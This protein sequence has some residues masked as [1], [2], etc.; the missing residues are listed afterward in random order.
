MKTPVLNSDRSRDDV[1]VSDRR[2]FLAAGIS[3]IAAPL[4]MER[5]RFAIGQAKR[6]RPPTQMELRDHAVPERNPTPAQ[7]RQRSP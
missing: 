4:L 3:L 7:V 1:G 6:H 2:Q 5:S